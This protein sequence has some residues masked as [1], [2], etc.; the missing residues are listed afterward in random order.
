MSNKKAKAK[1]IE[2]YGEECF[3]EKL[4]LRDDK[5]REYTGKGQYRKMK[6]I[7]YHHIREKRNGGKA[8]VENGALL[9]LENHRWFHEQSEEKQKEMNYKFQLY[10]QKKY[11]PVEIREIDS[12]E[13]PFTI[14][15]AEISIT[16]KSEVIIEPLKPYNVY[17]D[18]KKEEIELYKEHKKERNRKIYDKFEEER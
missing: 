15:T 16:E 3:I 6:S 11:T 18:M 17:K 5:D 12:I 2:M 13:F 7:T 9:S 8:T 4:H 14:K 1:L 10:K